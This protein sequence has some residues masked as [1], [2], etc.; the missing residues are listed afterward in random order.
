MESS[1]ITYIYALVDPETK[2]VRYELTK[3]ITTADLRIGR[4]DMHV[5]ELM[6]MVFGKIQ[7]IC[8]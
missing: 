6:R 7:I 1:P 5:S 3:P 8:Q 2:A 4:S